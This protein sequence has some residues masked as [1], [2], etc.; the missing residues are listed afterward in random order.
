MIKPL[1]EFYDPRTRKKFSTR[2]WRVDIKLGKQNKLR[3]YLVTIIPGT[4]RLAWR[5]TSKKFAEQY[6]EKDV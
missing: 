4:D 1:M 2:D 3:Y 6:I 5:I